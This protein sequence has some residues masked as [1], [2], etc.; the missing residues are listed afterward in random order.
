MA[1]PG[2]NNGV[3]EEAGDGA[4]F[5]EAWA[6][7]ELEVPPHLRDFAVAAQTGDVDALR[8]ALGTHH[9]ILLSVGTRMD[10]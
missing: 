4:L 1:V 3:E 9:A 7:P 5:D 10:V 2:R 6:E 8:V